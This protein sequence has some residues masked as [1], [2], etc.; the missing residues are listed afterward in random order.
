MKALTNQNCLK[1]EGASSPCLEFEFLFVISGVILSSLS[2]SVIAVNAASS[3]AYFQKSLMSD[4]KN[5]K[6]LGCCCASLSFH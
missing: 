3:A 6:G 2:L 4:V 5:D 1:S